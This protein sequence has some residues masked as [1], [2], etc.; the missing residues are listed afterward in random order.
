[1]HARCLTSVL[2]NEARPN[3]HSFAFLHKANSCGARVLKSCAA[4]SRYM[5]SFAIASCSCTD[6][7][8]LALQLLSALAVL[9]N[10]K[11]KHLKSSTLVC[12]HGNGAFQASSTTCRYPS[13]FSQKF[14]KQKR[15]KC[16]REQSVLSR[17]GA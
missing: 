12:D 4:S 6:P 2:C 15:L 9:H 8:C 13:H 11:P 17:S 7:I 10:L 3:E 1:M 16:G 5:I 14:S